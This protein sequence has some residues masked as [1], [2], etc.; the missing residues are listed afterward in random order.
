MKTSGGGRS[1]HL[2]AKGR[3]KLSERRAHILAK[4]NDKLGDWIFAF[5]LAAVRT[6]PGMTA[7]C[8][9]ECYARKH[10]FRYP[11]VRKALARN[12]KAAKQDDFAGRIASE[13]AARNVTV[14]RIHASGDF[15]SAAYVRQWTKVASALPEVV[16]FAYS[17]SWRVAEIR[18]ALG[19]LAALPNVRLWY[20]ADRETG[21]PA[22][23]PGGVRVAWL[24][25]T[26]DESVPEGV[27]LVF[28]PSRLRRRRNPRV[29][30][31]LVCPADTSDATRKV[32]C[33][34]CG[35]CWR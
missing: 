30:L 11:A 5:S 26:A 8:R 27:D 12:L 16:F 18:E 35:C 31:P 25:T 14:L 24:E 23:A 29:P 20:S 22:S 2:L 1:R 4:G 33:G 34:S 3:G 9:T 28:R 6:C 15:F 10:R 13:I 32:T 21:L 7:V 19:E 17:R